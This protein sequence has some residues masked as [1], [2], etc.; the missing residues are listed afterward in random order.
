M[1]FQPQPGLSRA[2]AAAIGK[3][4]GP[5]RCRCAAAMSGSGQGFTQHFRR[6]QF[7]VQRMVGGDHRGRERCCAGI[8]EQCSSNVGE[9]KTV[10]RQE[11]VGLQ[12][13]NV[14][15]P[16][17]LSPTAADTQSSQM[18]RVELDA[19][20]RQSMNRCRRNVAENQVWRP[21][22]QGNRAQSVQSFL[23][24]G[25][26]RLRR[27]VG[28]AVQ[29]RPGSVA[30]GPPNLVLGDS[31]RQQV[32]AIHD[33][34]KGRRLV[35]LHAPDGGKPSGQP[36]VAAGECA[37]VIGG[38]DLWLLDW[39]QLR[40]GCRVVNARLTWDDVGAAKS[41]RSRVGRASPQRLW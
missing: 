37:Q 40:P 3:Q 21:A 9:L 22:R 20:Q 13:R 23:V 38:A 30:T 34:G 6:D 26:H 33:G 2:L 1:H 12:L 29:P 27:A 25:G 8:V 32:L 4:H 18:N 14:D 17:G 10:A 15:D 5:P 41:W 24:Q 31:G 28:S 19:E 7:V 39:G 36:G 35:G 16:A 11:F